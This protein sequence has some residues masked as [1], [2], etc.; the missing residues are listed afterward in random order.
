MNEPDTQP[1]RFDFNPMESFRNSLTSQK[2]NFSS[3]KTQSRSSRHRPTKINA[4]SWEE[5]EDTKSFGW[6]SK[7]TNKTRPSWESQTS[8]ILESQRRKRRRQES[9]E[10]DDLE[11]WLEKREYNKSES[12]NQ[13][14]MRTVTTTPRKI[15]SSKMTKPPFQ[16]SHFYI[17]LI[18]GV[19]MEWESTK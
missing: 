3:K 13:W 12:V 15:Q 19:F 1:Y 11:C 14:A 4:H 5:S 17:C 7:E 9:L 18:F 6:R 8:P 16:F 10:E 2:S